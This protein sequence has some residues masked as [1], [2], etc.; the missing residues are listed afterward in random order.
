MQLNP[1]QQKR[2]RRISLTPLIDVVFLLLIFF[3]LSSS[4]LKFINIPV[5]GASQSSGGGINRAELA[6]LSIDAEG[7]IKIDGQVVSLDGLEEYLNEVLAKG[8]T[9]VVIRALEGVKAQKIIE[10]L[11]KARQ[12]KVKTIMLAR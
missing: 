3:M 7:Q 12:S 10:V 2:L 5:E 4:F 11:H 6:I 1:D 9:K 8:Q